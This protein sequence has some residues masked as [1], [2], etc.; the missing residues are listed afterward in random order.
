MKSRPVTHL[1]NEK[2]RSG[3]HD[4]AV[5]MQRRCSPMTGKIG[6]H[7]SGFGPGQEFHSFLKHPELASLPKGHKAALSLIAK[8]LDSTTKSKLWQNRLNRS[9]AKSKSKGKINGLCS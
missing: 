2:L 1:P 8:R 7:L 6:G 3:I 5:E 4:L 9:L